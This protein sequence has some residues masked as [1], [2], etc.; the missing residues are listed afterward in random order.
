MFY[1]NFDETDDWRLSSET[2]AHAVLS[3]RFSLKLAYILRYDNVPPS[4]YGSTDTTTTASV[5]WSF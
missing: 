1:P 2:A 3:R 4:G 5:V